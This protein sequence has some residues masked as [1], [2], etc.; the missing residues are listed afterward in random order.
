MLR[1]NVITPLARFFLPLSAAALVGMVGYGM[2]T[3]DMLGITLLLVVF[4][5]AGFAGTIVSGY[6]VNDAAALVPA[7]APAPDA[8]RWSGS[9][10]RVAGCGP[11]PPPCR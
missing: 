1:T 2:F 11:S 9:P 8:S 6:R 7:D 4:V 3:G 10:C 5:V